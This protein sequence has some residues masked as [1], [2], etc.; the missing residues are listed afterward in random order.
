VNLTETTLAGLARPLKAP[1]APEYP[2]ADDPAPVFGGFAFAADAPPAGA[3]VFVLALAVDER[4][5]PILV[6]DVDHLGEAIARALADLPPLPGAL[7]RLWMERAAPR[8]R[9]H[10]VR[11]LV[12]KYNPPL[13][14][15]NRTARAP[16]PVAA[17]APD[18]AAD[19]L[20]PAVE[21]GEASVSEEALDAL[22]RAFY[23]AARKDE[24]IGPVFARAVADWEGHYGTVRDF[25]S[26]ALLDTTR[27]SGFPFTVHTHLN[28]E[29]A[30]FD[31]WLAIFRSTARETLPPEAARR[32]ILKVESMSK[33]FQAGL[34]P[35]A[36]APSLA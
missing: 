8:Q 32:A 26:R 35:V 18:R 13:N 19:F 4:A 24:L 11:D 1:L 21:S 3:G 25:W 22:V 31:R 30:H 33:C 9:A 34:F 12:R 29:P 17:L 2:S 16:E 27:Y 5:Y 36:P 6:G 23:A 20:P 15:E 10:I 28:L 14:V 7:R